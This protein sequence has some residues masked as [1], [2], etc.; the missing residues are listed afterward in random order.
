MSGGVLGVTLPELSVGPS[1][2]GIDGSGG[3]A[4]IPALTQA[5]APQPQLQ[6]QISGFSPVV[7]DAI[8]QALQNNPGLSA[9]YMQQMAQIE[10]R[11]NPNAFNS[12]SKASG[13]YQFIPKTARNYELSNPFDPHANA[14]AAAQLAL[15]NKAILQKA[16]GRDP[17]DGELYLAHQQGAGGAAKLLSN[18]DAPVTSLVPARNITSNGGNPNMTAAQYAN[19]WTSKFGQSP[20]M[21]GN[22][23]AGAANPGMGAGSTAS[24]GGF[25]I[26]GIQA[27]GG[28]VAGQ[29]APPGVASLAAQPMTAMGPTAQSMMAGQGAA[30]APEQPSPYGGVMSALQGAAGKLG[31]AGQQKAGGGGGGMPGQPNIG[32]NPVS[33][34]QARQMFDPSKFF[35]MLQAHGVA[36]R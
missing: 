17:S 24:R 9:S 11:G 19:M 4:T 35:T 15:D 34:Q 3:M 25:G 14:N 2:A 29:A 22:V 18:P 1:V 10:S 27:Q 23:T 20:S 16:L 30:A 8:S 36:R 7:N 33:L 5:A 31:G 32:G 12:G 13:L 6:P 28:P 26:G 21:G